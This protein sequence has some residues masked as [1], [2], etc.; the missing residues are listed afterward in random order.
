MI[1]AKKIYE[2]I[3]QYNYDCGLIGGGTRG[4]QHF[5]ELIGADCTIMINWKGTLFVRR[6]P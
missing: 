2:M 4:I 5:T 6:E 3:K 1:V